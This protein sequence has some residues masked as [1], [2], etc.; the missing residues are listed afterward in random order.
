M[1]LLYIFLFLAIWWGI[2]F[3]L[4]L[5]TCYIEDNEATNLTYL[6]AIFGLFLIVPLFLI[7]WEKI[8]ESNW[9][10]KPLFKKR[11]NDT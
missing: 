2:G 4:W 1:I 6:V 10:E 7:L 3:L 11:E 9:M 8:D 5:L